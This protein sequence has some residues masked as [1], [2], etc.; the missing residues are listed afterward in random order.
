MKCL[1]HAMFYYIQFLQNSIN[2]SYVL[3][4]MFI[5]F[6]WILLSCNLVNK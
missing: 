6:N 2:P 1:L 4:N 3:F 5:Y